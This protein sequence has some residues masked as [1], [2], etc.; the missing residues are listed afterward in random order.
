MKYTL[1][2]AY[3]KLGMSEVRLPKAAPT[4]H[5]K[6]SCGGDVALILKKLKV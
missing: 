5:V 1:V 2:E 3:A 6:P 4:I